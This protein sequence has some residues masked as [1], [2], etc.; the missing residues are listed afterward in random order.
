MPATTKARNGAA[1]TPAPETEGRHGGDAA[2]RG[3]PPANGTHAAARKPAPL[4]LPPPPKEAG[5]PPDA[6]RVLA[7]FCYEEPGSPVTEFVTKVAGALADRGIAL[8]VFSR[9]GFELDAPGV[10][11][12]VLGEGDDENLLDRVQ[13]FTHR[14]C[15]AFLKQFQGTAAP[16]T[17]LGCEWSAAPVLSLLR[18]VKNLPTILSLHSVERQ[19]SDL[20]S[21]ESRQI[22]EI[23]LAGLREARVVLARDA[24]TAEVIRQVLPECADRTVIARERFPVH[25]FRRDLDPGAVKAR[26]EV[27]PIDPTILY[28][29]DLEERYGPDLLVKAMPAVLKNTPQARL[30]VVG[31]GG[32]YWPLRVYARYLL[33]EHAVR[34]PG[35]VEGDALCELIQAADVVVVPSREST[36][37]WP[38]LAAWAARRPV[39]ATHEAAPGLLEHEQDSVLCYPAINSCVWG[40]ERLLC[41]PEMGRALARRGARKLD[42]RFGWGAVAAQVE[43]LM[44]VASTR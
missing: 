39:V 33:L 40:V 4:L 8:H 30:V 37:W 31:A 34:L 16:V 20:T 28:V 42:E 5:P 19:R 18:G 35:S 15:N 43:E 25:E 10:S 12:H 11:V 29:G 23:E 17:L 26:Y 21:E 24:G 6:R 22:E 27:G 2:E 44:G 14:A 41:D 13:E 3:A 36:P 1:V 32:D 38:I 7:A 9:K